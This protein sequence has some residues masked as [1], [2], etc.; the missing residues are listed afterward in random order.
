MKKEIFLF[1]VIFL[2]G[3][4][5]LSSELLAIREIIPYVGSGT[6]TVSIVIAAVLMPL[7]VGYYVGGQFERDA[8]N[9]VRLKLLNN[10]FIASIFLTFGLSYLFIELF[11]NILSMIGLNSRILATTLYSLIFLV[12]PVFLLAQTI[13]LVS[14]FFGKQKLSLITGKMLFVSTLGSFLGAIFSTLVLMAFIGVHNTVIITL[15][16]LLLLYLLL[17]KVR[18][19]TKSTILM[20]L[21][22]FAVMVNSNQVM[23]SLNIVESNQYNTIKV[24][25]TNDGRTR[26][27]SLNNNKSS[28]ITVENDNIQKPL[29]GQTSF[30]YAD[31]IQQKIL[32]E[33]ELNGQTNSILVIGAGGFTIGLYDDENNYTYVDIDKSLKDVSE[34]Y[35]LKDTL[36]DNKVFAGIPARAFVSQAIAKNEKYDLIVIDIYQG[37]TNMPEH[38]TTAEFFNDVRK[39][40]ADDGVVLANIVASHIFKDV[41][42]QKIDNTLRTAFPHITRLVIGG[43]NV[44]DNSQG[45]RR[46]IIY[47][48]KNQKTSHSGIYTDNLNRVYYDKNKQV[49]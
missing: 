41:Y 42:S 20:A 39:I 45:T 4:V 23:K 36:S 44:W 12:T 27:L 43:M 7:A 30:K 29:T 33:L 28:M 5:V 14:H 16:C 22:I 18:I 32:P 31:F 26:L 15:G 2:E 11:F 24:I 40:S 1:F 21:F 35:F 6:D 13:P 25:E 8:R 38:L 17:A 9:T 34:K 37:G 47:I 48:F 3:Y 46:N 49:D 10:I 19:S